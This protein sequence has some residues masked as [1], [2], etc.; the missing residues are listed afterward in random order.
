M[1]KIS[2][3]LI[4][5]MTLLSVI[6]FAQTTPQPPASWIAFLKDESTKRAAFFQ[7]MH[8]DRQA[9]LSSHPD[10]QAYLDQMKANAK[11]RLAQRK[12]T[13]QNK[14]SPLTAINP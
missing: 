6:S 2:L 4:A 7:Q 5:S 14:I 11:A 13:H 12:G 8:A 9:F 1:K 10:A 3:G